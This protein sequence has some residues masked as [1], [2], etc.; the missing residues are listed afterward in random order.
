MK[1]T[2]LQ[3]IHISGKRVN[4]ALASVSG[5]NFGSFRIADHTRE[6]VRWLTAK[7]HVARRFPTIYSCSAGVLGD[8]SRPKRKRAQAR[9]SRHARR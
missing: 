5:A 1:S 7:T 6:L 8:T 9:H 3:Q 4:Q 2:A